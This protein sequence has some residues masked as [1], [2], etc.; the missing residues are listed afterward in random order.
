MILLCMHAVLADGF[1]DC[2]RVDA[3]NFETLAVVKNLCIYK[4][5]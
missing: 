3:G 5:L 1:L 4:F 2:L